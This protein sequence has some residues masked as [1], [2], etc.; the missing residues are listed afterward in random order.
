M[1]RFMLHALDRRRQQWKENAGRLHSLSPLGVL[2]RGYSITRQLPSGNIVRDA[3][4]ART[5]DRVEV[6]L[7]RGELECRVEAVRP[8]GRKDP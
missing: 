5:G 8:G 1:N 7:S 2:S 4:T 3:E 6:V